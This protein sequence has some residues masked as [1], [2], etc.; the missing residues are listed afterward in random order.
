MGHESAW[1]PSGSVAGGLPPARQSSVLSLVKLPTSTP[2]LLPHPARLG[3]DSAWRRP[4]A[5][6]WNRWGF[7]RESLETPTP[8]VSAGGGT[9]SGPGRGHRAGAS[10]A[11]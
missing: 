4:P 2:I 6:N 5:R 7:D 11:I 1:K 9:R 8:P 3:S 10:A